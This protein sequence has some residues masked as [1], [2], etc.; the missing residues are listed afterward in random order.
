MRCI[1]LAAT[2]G[3]GTAQGSLV[4]AIVRSEWRGAEAAEEIMGLLRRLPVLFDLAV[5]VSAKAP[6]QGRKRKGAGSAAGPAATAVGGSGAD[7]ETGDDG[8]GDD[9]A[10]P[11]DGGAGVPPHTLV[12]KEAAKAAVVNAMSHISCRKRRP[13]QATA[14]PSAFYLELESAC[15]TLGLGSVARDG[16]C[17]PMSALAAFDAVSARQYAALQG[18]G[19]MR[20]GTFP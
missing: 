12:P 18:S 14:D 16:T 4:E 20:H 7:G 19:V 9:A 15:R 1:M 5:D 17:T 11:S 13:S 2:D 8:E 6:Q 3:Y 10:G